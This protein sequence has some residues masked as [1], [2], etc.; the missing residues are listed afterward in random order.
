A[1]DEHRG[2]RL[3]QQDRRDERRGFQ[4][5]EI[6]RVTDAEAEGESGERYEERDLRQAVHREAADLEQKEDDRGGR[7]PD[8]ERAKGPLPLHRVV[9]PCVLFLLPADD[10]ALL[11]RL[12]DHQHLE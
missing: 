7:G 2:R 3:E 6:S 1:N 8:L 5:E 4:P 10:A 11:E 9:T 12:E